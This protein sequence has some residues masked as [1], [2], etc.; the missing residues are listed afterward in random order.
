[1]DSEKSD[2]KLF[3]AIF[4]FP[5]LFGWFIF[6][7]EH[8]V[9]LKILVAL[10]MVIATVPLYYTISTLINS[11]DDILD[12]SKNFGRNV[13]MKQKSEDK[14]RAY[15]RDYESGDLNAK[16]GSLGRDE[17]KI[18]TSELLGYLEGHRDLQAQLQGKV[19]N[20]TGEVLQK[21][22]T[23]TVYMKGSE[24]YPAIKMDFAETPDVESGD[25][26][27]GKCKSMLME[28]AGPSFKDCELVDDL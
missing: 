1:M 23:S 28:T 19:V 24:N 26:I 20:I 7:K 12:M 22:D 25:S 18:T 15:I 3:A 8:N 10:Y 17:L 13:S 4:A 2:W 9:F 21:P 11:K 16:P 27:T 14:A 6:K 5:Q